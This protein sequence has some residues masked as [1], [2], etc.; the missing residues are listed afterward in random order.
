MRRSEQYLLRKMEKSKFVISAKTKYCK[1]QYINM[2]YY[3][4]AYISVILSIAGYLFPKHKILRWIICR[5]R[6]R[7]IGNR[8]HHNISRLRKSR[9]IVRYQ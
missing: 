2:V 6:K 7:I 1:V 8:K 5:L 9:K 3:L 4:T